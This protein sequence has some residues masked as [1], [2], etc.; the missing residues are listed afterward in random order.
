ML[1]SNP[2]GLV[3]DVY[4]GRYP[5]HPGV[6]NIFDGRYPAC[7]GVLGIPYTGNRLGTP[8]YVPSLV[9]IEILY[10]PDFVERAAGMCRRATAQSFG[11]HIPTV[12]ATG[13]S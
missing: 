2:R 13:R 5:A 3:L 10:V 4:G 12:E 7:H 11:L 6:L 1:M 9:H 8:E